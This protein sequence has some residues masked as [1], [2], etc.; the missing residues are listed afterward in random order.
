MATLARSAALTLG[1]WV[2]IFVN[3]DHLGAEQP[4]KSAKKLT[5][6]RYVDVAVPP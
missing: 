4:V 5:R 6:A 2:D 1:E 3:F